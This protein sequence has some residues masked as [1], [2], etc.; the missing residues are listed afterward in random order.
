MHVINGLSM[1]NVFSLIK[2]KSQSLDEYLC[3]ANTSFS[4]ENIKACPFYYSLVSTVF[5]LP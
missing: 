2:G 5:P 1:L 3:L 4:N